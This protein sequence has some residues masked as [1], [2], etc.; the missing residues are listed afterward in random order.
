[1]GFAHVRT[2]RPLGPPED[3]HA[4]RMLA[5]AFSGDGRRLASIGADGSLSTSLGRPPPHASQCVRWL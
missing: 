1:M 4:G 5:L 2:R 3:T